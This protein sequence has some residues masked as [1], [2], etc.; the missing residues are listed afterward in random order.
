M[1]RRVEALDAVRGSALVGIGLANVMWFSGYAVSGPQAHAAFATAGLDAALVFALH[2]L[3]DGKFYGLFSLLFG[4]GFALLVRGAGPDAPR[5]VRTRLLR[6]AAIGS[7]HAWLLWFG[8]IVSLYAV[9]AAPLWFVHRWPSSRLLRLAI[10]C[11]VA[12]VVITGL[13]VM[14]MS[15]DAVDPGHG[16][17]ALLPAFANGSYLDVVRANAA[18]VGER[19]AR[20]LASSRLIRIFGLFVLGLVAARSVLLRKQPAVV[21]PPP[22]WL[23]A[24]ALGSNLVLASLADVPVRPPTVAGALREAVYSVAI[25]SGC[26]LYAIVLWRWATRGGRIVRALAAAG[27]LSLTHYLGQSMVFAALFYGY[28]FGLWGKLGASTAMLVAL[29]LASLQVLASRLV[30]SRRGP[31]ERLLRGREARRDKSKSK[32]VELHL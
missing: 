11:L 29:L 16:P 6:L 30:G 27:R 21:G 19:W 1:N 14:W 18:F 23:F 2:V 31:F 12:P 3:V 32:A 4:V 15:S 22:A 7:L 20:A 5:R 9:A 17:A 26:V 10:A 13:R 25:P 24:L 8:D 28:G